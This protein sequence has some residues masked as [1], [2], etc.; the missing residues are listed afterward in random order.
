VTRVASIFSQTLQLFLRFEFDRMV[1]EHKAERH[2]RG[3][4]C[5]GQLVAM[6]FCQLGRA[7]S[8]REICNGLAASEGK[9][10]H[11]GLPHAD[12]PLSSVALPLRLEPLQ[13][14]RQQL[15]VHRPLWSWL[16]D[17]LSGSTWRSPANAALGERRTGVI[18]TAPPNQVGGICE[19]NLN[20]PCFQHRPTAEDALLV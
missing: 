13:L 5:W 2:A 7:H 17:P 19:T 11:L 20:V 12:P 1:K 3:F 4:T 10:R 15:F 6:L 8:L 18:W 9:L 14:L 16:D